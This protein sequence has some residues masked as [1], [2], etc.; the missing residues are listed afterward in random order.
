[1]DAICKSEFS[2]DSQASLLFT[3][4]IRWI[5]VGYAE[6]TLRLN[7]NDRGTAYP[8]IVVHFGRCLDVSARRWLASFFLVELVSHSDV[9]VARNDRDVF[10]FWMMMGG[11]FITA[12][13]L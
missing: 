7:L 4:V 9:E 10:I 3:R 1:M 13:H 12:R 2:T 6:R 8:T 11:E 5:G